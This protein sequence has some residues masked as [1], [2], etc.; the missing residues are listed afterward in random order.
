MKLKFLYYYY[1]TDNNHISIDELIKYH[2]I[3]KSNYNIDNILDIYNNNKSNKYKYYTDIFYLLIDEN[4]IK[5]TK[6]LIETTQNEKYFKGW[7]QVNSNLY[8]FIN[9]YFIKSGKMDIAL[10]KIINP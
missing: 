10:K 2:K 7:I 6:Y 5:A 3:N 4:N 1:I 9:N 8:N